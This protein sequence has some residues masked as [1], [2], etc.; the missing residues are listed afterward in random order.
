M[1]EAV[2]GFSGFESLLSSSVDP[3][4]AQSSPGCPGEHTRSIVHLCEAGGQ[5]HTES[6]DAGNVLW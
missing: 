4:T 6:Q 2:V 1:L 5:E 3:H